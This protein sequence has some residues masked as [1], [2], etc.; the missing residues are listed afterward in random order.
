MR[1]SIWRAEELKEKPG[2]LPK[3]LWP[4]YNPPVFGY[5][6]NL[7]ELLTEQE[8]LLS[9]L[10]EELMVVAVTFNEMLMLPHF[11]EYYRSLGFSCFIIAD[12]LSNDGIREYPFEQEDVIQYSADSQYKSSLSRVAW[13]QA[14]LANHCLEKWALVA[15]I[16]EFLVYPGSEEKPLSALTQELDR[17][18]H[19]AVQI[20]MID[21]YPEGS[22]EEADLSRA[23]PFAVADYFDWNAIKTWNLSKGY[24]SDSIQYTSSLRHRL[25]PI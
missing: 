3:K 6:E 1:C 16:D 21:M 23:S 13:Q 18:G 4:S 20:F 14:M 15:D 19:N 8:I 5:D 10:Q 11:L 24:F 22:L 12:N 9:L 25:S 2:L 17:A 7:L